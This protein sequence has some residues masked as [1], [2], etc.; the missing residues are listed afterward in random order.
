M[1]SLFTRLYAQRPSPERNQ[2]ENFLTEA[3]AY[4]LEKDAG[5]RERW[6]K[7]LGW[8][9]LPSTVACQVESQKI[10]PGSQPDIELRGTDFKILIECKVDSP[11]GEKQLERYAAILSSP[12]PDSGKVYPANRQV[13]VYLTRHHEQGKKPPGF[14]GHFIYYRW[15]LV[16]DLV[17]T[18]DAPFT[19]E[20]KQFL[21]DLGMSQ[22]DN[23]NYHDL[24]ALLTI[25]GTLR[26]MDAA[27]NAVRQR[28]I[29]ELGANLYPSNRSTAL[30][31]DAAYYNNAFYKFAHLDIGFTWWKG[32]GEV[33]LYAAHLVH[34]KTEAEFGRYSRVEEFSRTGGWTYWGEHKDYLAWEKLKPLS[35]ILAEGGNHVQ[36]ISEW[37]DRRIIEWKNLKA[38]VPA[39]FEP[40]KNGSEIPTGLTTDI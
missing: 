26:K 22:N 38:Q 8:S 1:P 14:H 39:F 37:F 31:R 27:L 2:L 17:Q 21:K 18:G 20:L 30:Q 24:N 3:F 28:A 10:Y 5:F 16:H 29:S 25:H 36:H 33:Y 23:F 12:E 9:F 4:V 40:L 7:S 34:K 19:L 6:L 32:D 15:F 11:E 13:L 35:Q